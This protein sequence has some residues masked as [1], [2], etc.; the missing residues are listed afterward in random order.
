MHN[1]IA[2]EIIDCFTYNQR[3]GTNHNGKRD[4]YALAYRADS[5]SK[6]LYDGKTVTAP[7]GAVVFVPSGVEYTTVSKQGRIYAVHFK[8]FNHSYHDI[9]VMDTENSQKNSELF[10]KILDIWAKK[11]AGYKYK[12]AGIFYKILSE[13]QNIGQHEKHGELAIA[14][15][16]YLSAK[17][18]DAGLTISRVASMLYVSDAYLR[19]KFREYYGMSPKQYLT[20]R[21]IEFAKYLIEID[22]F[23]QSEIA[24]R[25]GF[26][27][28]KYFRT[29]FKKLTG[30]SVGQYK[31]KQVFYSNSKPET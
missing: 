23:T 11:E 8:I 31:R 22:C 7:C 17:F 26:S 20:E 1:D 13:M 4:F 19:K 3:K 29:A 9:E 30:K 5:Q 16:E 15:S 25:C 21:R 28:V 24:E 10:L 14:C 12:T 18:S 6:Y 27:G 2:V